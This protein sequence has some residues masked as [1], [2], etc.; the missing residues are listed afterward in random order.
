MNIV[1]NYYKKLTALHWEIGFLDN[2][3]SDIVNG[4]P[5]KIQLVTHDYPTHW[6]ADPFI[7]EVNDKTI[8]V[9]VED[10]SFN[11]H[12]GRISKLVINKETL[13]VVERKVILE[14]P[15]HLSFPVIIRKDDKIYIMPENSA[16]GSLNLYEYNSK[17]D[18]V[19]FK[20]K[21]CNKPLT[22][23]IIVDFFG[24]KQL[25]ATEIPNDNGF[26]LDQYEWDN[27]NDEFLFCQSISFNERIARMA[28]EFF[29]VDNRIFRPAQESN[30]N[31]G[32]G[33]SIQ[34]VSYDSGLWA[35][36]EVRRLV[37]PLPE[38]NIG[39][40]T[41]NS[42]DG[43]LIVDVKGYRHPFMGPLL[44]KMNQFITKIIKHA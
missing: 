26:I 2:S 33:I 38:M 37:S 3:Y 41:L 16:D 28:G 9:L 30:S 42:Y 34:E 32:H 20:K 36:T 18:E 1:K 27:S 23:A 39:F 29:K 40:H 35:F 10:V 15:G 44:V 24:K 31:Y 5:I 13:H 14:R 25:F 21:L 17:T 19:V 8:V 6:F 22:D 7:L 43:L 4:K 11:F 12:K